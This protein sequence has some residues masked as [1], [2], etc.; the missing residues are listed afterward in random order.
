MYQEPEIVKMLVYQE[1][2]IV[3]MLFSSYNS[4]KAVFE[5]LQGIRESELRL[6]QRFESYL[7]QRGWP[8]EYTLQ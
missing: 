7:E 2:E 1:P 4:I 8:E 5:D 6:D 3:K